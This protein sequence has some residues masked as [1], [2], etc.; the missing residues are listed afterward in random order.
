MQEAAA[1]A[2]ILHRSVVAEANQFQ[3]RLQQIGDGLTKLE[4]VADPAARAAAKE[5]IQLLMEMHGA[6]L[7]RVLEILFQSGEN[8]AR[9][10]DELARDPEVSSLLV[11]YGLHPEDLETRVLRKLDEV[12]SR[13]FKMGA[14]AR[15]V[16]VSGSEV[17]VQVT[18]EGHACGSTSQN[19]RAVVEEAIYEAA[20][21]LTSLI[22]EG[23]DDPKPSGFVAMESLIGNTMP[24]TAGHVGSVASSGDGQD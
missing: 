15:L 17:R 20:P 22:V 3:R 12:R 18:L 5:L 7:N 13:L 14:E 4:S 11:L 19:V 23:L 16:S 21:E 2:P 6:A 1:F 10:I 24:R 9:M 8:G